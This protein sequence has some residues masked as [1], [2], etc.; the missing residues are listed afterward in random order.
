MLL[1]FWN[2]L[3]SCNFTLQKEC[4]YATYT[5]NLDMVSLTLVTSWAELGGW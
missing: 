1:Q 5:I 2:L 3:T 4:T